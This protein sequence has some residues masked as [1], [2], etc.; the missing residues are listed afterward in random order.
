MS[1]DSILHLRLTEGE[2]V[3]NLNHVIPIQTLILKTV[4]VEM[5]GDQEAVNDPVLTIEL[6]SVFGP[7]QINNSN[8]QSSRLPVFNGEV[9]VNQYQTDWAIGLQ[10]DMQRSFEYKVYGTDGNLMDDLIF[11][12]IDLVFNYGFG[13]ITG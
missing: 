9:A 2:G 5:T 4:R 7:S 3:I 13:E 8:T 10:K 1:S 11:V 6:S 12:S